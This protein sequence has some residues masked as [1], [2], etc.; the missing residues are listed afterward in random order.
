M[1]NI[2]II[3]MSRTIKCY[4]CGKNGHISQ[5]SLE[6]KSKNK[7]YCK[8]YKKD[9]HKRENCWYSNVKYLKYFKCGKMGHQSFT[10]K[11]E[12]NGEHHQK[13]DRKEKEE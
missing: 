12:G 5:I 6:N 3:D 1:K 7:R 9:G 2:W 13:E 8:C 4:A 10:C 11:S